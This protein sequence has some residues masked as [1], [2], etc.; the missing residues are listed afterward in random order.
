MGHALPRLN[1]HVTLS[2]QYLQSNGK[3]ALLDWHNTLSE[4]MDTS[5]AQRL[6]GRHRKTLLPT[7]RTLLTPEFSFVKNTAKLCALKERQ[8]R[9]FNHGKRVL[10]PVFVHLQ[11]Y[12]DQLNASEKLLLIV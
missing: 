12:G 9:Y 4:G 10:S 6:L 1:S 7:S 2:P 3:A 11:E 5:P 8:H